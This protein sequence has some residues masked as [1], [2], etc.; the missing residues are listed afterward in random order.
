MIRMLNETKK[1]LI[2]EVRSSNRECKCIIKIQSALDTE[3]NLIA[4]SDDEEDFDE[5][6]LVLGKLNDADWDNYY[7]MI[8]DY[9][10]FSN[11]TQF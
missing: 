7:M 4:V 9:D 2:Q 1:R 10:S 3:C 8:G 6:C 11:F 5:F